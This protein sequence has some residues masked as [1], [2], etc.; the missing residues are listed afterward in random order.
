[1]YEVIPGILEKE[2]SEIEKKLEI[3]KPFVKT[4]HIDLLDGKFV[5]STTFFDPSPFKRYADDIFFELHMMV[6]EP[7]QYVKAW[8]SA[9][10]KRFLGHV[11]LMSDQREFVLKANMYGQA[12]LALDG[13]TPVSAINVDSENLDCILVYTSEK[14]GFSGPPILP[15]R[16]EKVKKMQSKTNTSIEVDGGIKNTTI[17][18]AI[19][20]GATR[21][22]SASF[23]FDSDNP[24]LQYKLLLDQCQK[25][26]RQVI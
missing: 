5:E 7:I 23:I 1:M 16:L 9:G 10:F 15:S 17:T 11:E 8:A 4:V 26:A 20:A 13:P 25:M 19:L 6:E 14:V 21:F 2:W 18:Q 22:V 12:G 24:R 3:V